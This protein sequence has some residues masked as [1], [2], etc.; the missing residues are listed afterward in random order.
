MNFRHVVHYLVP[1]RLVHSDFRKEV[2]LIPLLVSKSSRHAQL[3]AGLPTHPEAAKPAVE[4]KQ[5]Q[6]KEFYI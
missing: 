5:S 3:I 4:R 1:I 6:L 2:L